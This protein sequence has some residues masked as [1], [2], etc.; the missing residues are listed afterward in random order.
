MQRAAQIG[1]EQ[2]G[3]VRRVCRGPQLRIENRGKREY[4]R[5]V[6]ALTGARLSQPLHEGFWKQGE[7]KAQFAFCLWQV[8]PSPNSFGIEE[9]ALV[10]ESLEHLPDELGA[11]RR[12][13]LHMKKQTAM[14]QH[15]R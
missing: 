10:Y 6:Q 4:P 15:Q 14:I 5:E 7:Q 1:G 13:F 2:D 8:Q 9:L 11:R 3:I 12:C